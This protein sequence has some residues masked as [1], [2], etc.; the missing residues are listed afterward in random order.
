MGAEYDF[1]YPLFTPNHLIS[2][3][4]PRNVL[5]LQV[6]IVLLLI[7]ANGILAMSELAIVSARTARLQQMASEGKRGAAVALELASDPNK[8]LSSVQIGITLIGVLNGA[9][10]GA[11]LS[12]P[13]SDALSKVPGLDRYSDQI[14]VAAVVILIT[15]LSLVIGELVPKQLALQ[16]GEAIASTMAP[17]LKN[18]ARV[19]R[20]IVALL[21]LSSTFVLNLIG[22][23]KQ[24]GSG[25]TE[26]EVRLLIKQ[27]TEDGVFEESQR[28]MV[29]QIFKIADRN[30][31]EL[32]TP[33]HLIDYLDLQ[34][35]DDWNRKVM[36]DSPHTMYPVTEGS[37]DNVV[38]VV[39]SR[40]LWH[41]TVTGESTNIRDSMKPALFV[42]QLAPV[43]DVTEQMRSRQSPMAIVIDEYGGLDGLLTFNDLISDIIGELDVSDPTAIKGAVQRADGSWLLDGVLAAHEMMELLHF[44]S[45]PGEE[46][47]RFETTAGFVMDQLGHIPTAGEV[48]TWDDFE[49]EV[50]DMDG[51]RIDKILVSKIQSNIPYGS[52]PC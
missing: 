43:L 3:K 27:G 20:P 9:F 34:Q 28:E 30:V 51:N 47:G 11:T 32:M 42:P 18:L 2:G 7:V 16:R 26:E 12:K 21:A 31:G 48:V 41:R 44:D 45:L 23:Q 49:F 35:D 33:R 1:D 17:A 4:A 6:T 22:S 29:S 39:S 25:V 5:A 38:G 14:G 13:V 10:G 19:T 52:T 37:L 46:E 24:S 15:Y 36:I 40:E 50:I 8:F